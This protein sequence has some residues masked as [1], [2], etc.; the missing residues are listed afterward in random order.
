MQSV[1]GGSRVWGGG[2]DWRWRGGD[3]KASFAWKLCEAD[4]G[5]AARLVQTPTF[6][7]LPRSWAD[8][9]GTEKKRK[10]HLSFEFFSTPLNLNLISIRLNN[11]YF[12]YFTHCCQQRKRSLIWVSRFYQICWVS[13]CFTN[14]GFWLL[15]LINFSLFVFSLFY[16]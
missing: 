2:G 1:R 4:V 3:N 14:Q 8:S 10:G 15:F 7:F 9:G 13:Y 11:N 5:W 6:F 16:V 12:F